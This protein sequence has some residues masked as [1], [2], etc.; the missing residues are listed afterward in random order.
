M[1][2][3]YLLDTNAYF[4]ILK[5]LKDASDGDQNEMVEVLKQG[6]LFISE[7]TRIEIISVLGKYARGGN[8]GPQK[9]E[10]IISEDGTKCNHTRYVPS[11]KKWSNKRVKAWIKLIQETMEGSSSL[12]NVTQLPFSSATI[13][14]ADGIIKHALIHSFGSLDAMIAAT[15]QGAIKSKRDMV[16][17]TS[18]RPLKAC[19]E[20]CS[21][22]YVDPFAKG[23]LTKA[24]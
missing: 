11:R 18:D 6:T 3:E 22:P 17:V 5:L 20:K 12:I 2:K 24:S 1:T 14:E 8:G 15:A 16:V 9:C 23:P 4:N 10:C 13:N 21:I 19:L 7:I